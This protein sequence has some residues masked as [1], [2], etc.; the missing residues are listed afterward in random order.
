MNEIK[1]LEETEKELELMLEIIKKRRIK[2]MKGEEVWK[3]HFIESRE[4]IRTEGRE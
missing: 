3:N 1:F 2:L 4:N